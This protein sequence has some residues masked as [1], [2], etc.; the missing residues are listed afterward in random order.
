[1]PSN[2]LLHFITKIIDFEGFKATN[3]YFID[4]HELLVVLE[5]KSRTATCP[6]CQKTTDKIH[7]SHWYRVRDIPW[8]NFDIFLQVNRRQFRCRTCQKVFSEQLSFVKKRRTYSKRLAEKVVKEVLET[9]IL[10]IGKR[11]RMT[12]AEL[13]TLLKEVEEEV[14]EEK[15]RCLTNYKEADSNRGLKTEFIVIDE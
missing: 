11:N 12:P 9:D 8:S 3:Y 13:E 6:H 15:P 10:N 5:K 1:M 14:S 7:Q 4:D 2:S